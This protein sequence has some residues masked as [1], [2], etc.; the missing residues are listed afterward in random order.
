M[1]A[2]L[3]RGIMLLSILPNGYDQTSELRKSIRVTNEALREMEVKGQIK[4]LDIHDNFLNTQ[5]AWKR[6]L[7]LDGTHLTMRGYELWMNLLRQPL[8][9]A[10]R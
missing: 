5:G 8:A 2:R 4:F 1:K 7:T 9:E 6:S 3:S 10:L